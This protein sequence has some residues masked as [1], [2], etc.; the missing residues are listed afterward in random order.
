MSN[1]Y[2]TYEQYWEK[3]Q[4]TAGIEYDEQKEHGEGGLEDNFASE[5]AK[6]TV[7]WCSI[8]NNYPRSIIYHTNHGFEGEGRVL[9]IDNR[10]FEDNDPS[11]MLHSLASAAYFN[12]VKAAIESLLEARE[13]LGDCVNL[14]DDDVPVYSEG[15]TFEYEYEKGLR[16]PVII[17]YYLEHISEGEWRVLDPDGE[18]FEVISPRMMV[19]DAVVPE[20][21]LKLKLDNLCAKR[22]RERDE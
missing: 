7:E 4:R 15:V 13:E 5:A 11:E 22:E 9:F 14:I 1:N 2:E 12:D 19:D 18:Q 16:D 17:T 20:K 6:A 3:V 21:T 8:V 10:E